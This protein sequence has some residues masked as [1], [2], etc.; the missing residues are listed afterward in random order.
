MTN[1][2]MAR[3]PVR[4]TTSSAAPGVVSMTISLNGM[5]CPWRKRL[6][7]RQSGH[8][9]DEYTTSSIEISLRPRRDLLC[10]LCGK[11]FDSKERKENKAASVNGRLIADI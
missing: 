1:C 3:F 11:A 8:Q 2:G 7:T 6:A 9:S 5:L 4:A 10:V